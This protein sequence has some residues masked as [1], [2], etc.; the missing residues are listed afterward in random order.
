MCELTEGTRGNIGLVL[1]AWFANGGLGNAVQTKPRSKYD[2]LTII[3]GGHLHL[4]SRQ[5]T[6]IFNHDCHVF[7]VC[8]LQCC[9]LLQVSLCCVSCTQE[10]AY[11]EC[12]PPFGDVFQTTS[13]PMSMFEHL[14]LHQYYCIYPKTLS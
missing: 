5:T 6:K 14:D 4:K 8:E 9:Y 11:G 1:Q 3:R 12:M 7:I 10:I 2:S 13:N